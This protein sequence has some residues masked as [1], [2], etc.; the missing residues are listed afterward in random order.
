EMNIGNIDEII[1]IC[2]L[3]V[4][5]LN[6]NEIV[7]ID[8]YH[9]TLLHYAVSILPERHIQYLLEN[10]ACDV[11]NVTD[12]YGKT[13]LHEAAKWGNLD[14]IKLLLARKNTK[15]NINILDI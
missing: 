12:K 3:F 15:F 4:P 10:G 8:K 9:K 6:R 1:G 7:K 11:L 2:D 5:H 13:V 14:A